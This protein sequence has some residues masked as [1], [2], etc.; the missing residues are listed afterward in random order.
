[1][2]VSPS[3]EAAARAHDAAARAVGRP[4]N[5]PGPGEEKAVKA[6][7]SSTP[8]VGVLFDLKRQKWKSIYT[9]KYN[10]PCSY[11]PPRGFKT[12]VVIRDPFSVAF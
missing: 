10:T 1:M 4:V 12:L 7:L 5:F 9:V 8:Y 6:R 2:L 3:L 11:V